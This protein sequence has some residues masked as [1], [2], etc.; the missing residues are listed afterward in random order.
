MCT[1]G[2][3]E[4]GSVG[5]Q[6]VRH[7]TSRWIEVTRSQ[8]P[9][10]AEGLAIVRELLPD[11]PP[12]RA[13]SN[14][15][16]RDNHG[17]W[18][19]VDLLVLGRRRLHLVELKWYRGTLRGDDHRW[20]RDGHPAEDSPL[21]LTRRKAQRLATRLKDELRAWAREHGQEIPDPRE[22]IPF[23]Q[24]AVFLHHP[25]LVCQLGSTARIDLFGLDG[26]EERMHLP[27]IASRL[28]EPPTP[29]ESVGPNR[30][31]IIAKLL[32]RIGLVQRR[33]R[34]V[35]S[36]IIDEEPLAEGDGWQDWPAFH[37]V[38]TT[39]R[40][41][42]R[43]YV[44]PPG[45]A[46]TERARL[47]RV[48][49]HE[50][51]TMSRMAHDGLLKPVD[52]VD[53]EL[54]TGLVYPYDERTRR[55]D[56]W[57]AEQRDGVPATTQ[58]ALLR[59]VAEAVGYAHR[60]RVVHRGLTPAAVHVR[61]RTDREPVVLVGDWQ[62][63]G[64]TGDA[65]ASSI[66]G[67][68]V[69]A[70]PGSSGSGARL[71][72]VLRPGV[73]LDRRFA[74]VFQAP[75]GVW[76][77]A[78]DR[79]RL[80]VFSLGA[81]AYYLVAGRPPASDRAGL[82]ERLQRD[83]GLDLAADLPQV[84]P[85]LRRLV[86]GAT[87]P[88]VPD[89]I[90]DVATFLVRLA[91]A[92]REVALP[93]DL[94][95]TDPLEAAPG[96]VLD[97]RYR[98]E[99]RLGAGSTAVGLLV[100]DLAAGDE[101]RVLKVAI[102][103]AAA[104]RLDA[105]AEV[106]RGLRHPRLVR[107]V[108]GPIDVG[109][110]RV[111]LLEHAGD[112]TLAEV[113]RQRVRLS[114][115]LLAR[116]GADLLE[117][118]VALDR[119]G[120]DHRDIKPANLGVREG[121]GDRVKH[122]VLFDFSL[123][124]AGATA[125]NAGTPP[126]LDPFLEARGRYDSAA[127]RY[128]AAVVLFEAATGA[129]PVFGDGESLPLVVKDE[130]T[131]TPGLFDASVA[132][133]CVAFF[134]RSLARDAAARHDTAADMLADWNAIFAPVGRTVPDDIAERAE[135]ADPSTT[136]AEAGLSAWALSALEP[137]G[138]VTV[139]DLAAID[140]VRLNRLAGVADATRR[141]VKAWAR[142]WRKRFAGSAAPPPARPAAGEALPSP[143]EAA[144]L[145]AGSAGG[146]R[147]GTKRRAAELLVGTAGELDPFASRGE[148]GE[149]LGVSRVRGSQ[150][151]SELQD[152]WARE[153]ESRLLL[154]TLGGVI[155][156]A[157]A[158]LAGVTT[159]A[160]LVDEV[161]AQLAPSAGEPDPA[162]L[163]AGLVR[164]TLDRIDALARADGLDP[165]Q[166]QLVTRRREGRVA[167]LATDPLL[168]DAAEAAARLA[169]ALV[170]EA[171]EAGEPVVP[172]QRAATAL[173]EAAAR[174]A[175]GSPGLTGDRLARLAV[176][177]SRRAVLSGHG[178][179]HDRDLPLATAI[180]LALGGLGAGEPVTATE[181]RDRVRARFPALPPMPERP[182]LD[183]L[184]AEAGV[185]LVYDE[186]LRKYRAEQPPPD[187]TGLGTAPPSQVGLAAAVT[188]S[189]GGA[190][191]QRLR[192]SARSRSFLALGVDAVRVDRAV[193]LLAHR[194]DATIVDVTRVLV[195]ALRAQA[196]EAGVPWELVRAADAAQPGT[197]DAMGLAAL[198]EQALPVIAEA[199]TA[200]AA[201]APE[202]VRPVV[203]TELSPLARYGHL[204]LLAQWS[205][206]AAGRRQAIWAVVP[207]MVNNYGPLVDG[208]PLPLAAPGQF[209]R[210]DADWLAA[211]PEEARV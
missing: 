200:A 14:F 184:L 94:L 185:P 52:V 166:P 55:L 150:L 189:A 28:L 171:V 120:V 86:L 163:A 152:A 142:V 4:R 153:A 204:A 58:L 35:G 104:Q 133:A 121:R 146:R 149:A 25:D 100:T 177:L 155:R 71:A 113:L 109:G 202:G 61:M 18:H 16:F 139:G 187:T 188:V 199:V 74:E 162:R 143:H 211:A 59:R 34:E 31:E 206:L 27:G 83:G 160:E 53:D 37:R 135:Q 165:D 119:A 117:A 193:E 69:T 84:S 180:G 131:V 44:T 91:D 48:A 179:L 159:V 68:G 11:A 89:R 7:D 65:A 144:G 191:G 95:A 26:A 127:E 10:E 64:T 60:H 70:L 56:L 42:I 15:E 22:V 32:A 105:E 190:A 115:D 147:A 174:V 76:N 208:R 181:V 111:L 6:T 2:K 161:L 172:R 87:R 106:L 79:V 151:V 140:P 108:D 81:L 75:E 201:G 92:E 197:R 43:F 194:H 23:V 198:V 207:Q 47:R 73:D 78:A 17:K 41:R 62:I 118:L 156:E 125:I 167:M 12:F 209:L 85:A 45:A 82:R 13:W 107:L 148:L 29:Y 19:E 136:L 157:V 158:R 5:G 116:W 49:E 63:A 112:Q 40:T 20:L 132:G 173:A 57:L 182:R 66:G 21:K 210:L 3:A 24:E 122:L 123:A 145:L 178:E 192:E 80:D 30:D 137:L 154:E 50:Y 164:A 77:R 195:G 103:D 168:F 114:L 141:E 33:Q 170:A 90:G 39:D 67:I 88:A 129:L 93:A 98:L 72:A 96:A 124:R 169:D 175:T 110:R 138:V 176:R 196:A 130:A 8:F 9:F 183:E 97:G 51:R 203:L 101:Q 102:D 128:A 54:G 186:R 46:A 205:D 99:R 36:W 126:Y 1:L 38:A 134:R